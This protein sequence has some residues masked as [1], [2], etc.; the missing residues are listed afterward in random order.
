MTTTEALRK[1][2]FWDTLPEV[3]RENVKTG[4]IESSEGKRKSTDEVMKKYDQWRTN[5]VVIST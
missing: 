4:K 3:V 2:D 1:Q 5:T